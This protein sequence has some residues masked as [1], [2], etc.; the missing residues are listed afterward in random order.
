MFWL[1]TG[2]F[3]LLPFCLRV[4]FEEMIL[5]RSTLVVFLKSNCRS[6]QF[7]RKLV[8]LVSIIFRIRTRE[9]HEV[10]Y[11]KYN[12]IYRA[13][14]N[15]VYQ[16]SPGGGP[17]DEAKAQPSTRSTWPWSPTRLGIR[18]QD[19]GLLNKYSLGH[20][21]LSAASRRK[22]AFTSRHYALLTAT[23]ATALY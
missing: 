15:S 3:D 1:R 10:F 20:C 5:Q 23:D 19:L 4:S 6:S 18:P 8:F 17:G 14:A 13:C 22:L 9:V 21:G 12:G 16:A 11:G 2:L 7:R